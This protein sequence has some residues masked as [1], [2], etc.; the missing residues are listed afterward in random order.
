MKAAGPGAIARIESS[1]DGAWSVSGT[2]DLATVTA[3]RKTGLEWFA[4]ASE[5][6][7]DLAG[8]SDA[9]SG[10]LAL[11]VEWMND[12]RARGSRFAIRGLPD[13]LRSIA[14]VTGLDGVLP[15]A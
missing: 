15:L 8:V 14:R 2:L 5:V 10:A 1:A 6:V 7:V 3:L 4:G 12:C 9:D 13:Q 11:L